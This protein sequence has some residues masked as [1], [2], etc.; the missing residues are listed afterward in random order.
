MH[1]TLKNLEGKKVGMLTIESF[2]GIK[3]KSSYWN[4]I[5]DCGNK[6]IIKGVT[7]N[8]NIIKSCGCGRR[9]MLIERNSTH[10]MT[11]TRFYKTWKSMRYRCYNKNA[12]HYY[13]YGGRGISVCDD[14]NIFVNFKNDMYIKYLEHVKKFGEKNT[15]IDRIDVNGNY[16]KENCRWATISI[17]LSN[18]TNN[19]IIEFSGNKMTINQWSEKLKINV[20]TL[21]SRLKIGLPLNKVFN[22]FSD[23]YNVD[24]TKTY[25][26][27]I[28]NK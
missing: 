8:L 25:A 5:C 18:K 28:R 7:L 23:R 2:H 21:T 24:L 22:K 27:R 10:G 20:N 19:R 13:N 1:N 26:K 6:K 9:K 12:S 11:K 15:S 16:C 14:W 3:D 17:Q 4:C